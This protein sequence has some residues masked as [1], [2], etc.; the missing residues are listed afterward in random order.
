[1]NHRQTPHSMLPDVDH[2]ENARQDFVMNF[3]QHL[4]H[5]VNPGTTLAYEQRVEPA[6][7]KEHS[8]KPEG[9]DEV[10]K[11]MT[12]DPY[13]QIWSAMQRNSQM[14]MWDS[15]IDSVERTLP[16]MID[17]A[18]GSNGPSSARLADESFEVPRY[19][20]S[21][22]IHLQPGGYHTDSA[23]EDIAAGMIY[24]TAVPIYALGMMG[25]ENDAT[26]E[27]IVNFYKTNYAHHTPKRVLDLGCAIGNSTVP[28]AKAYPDAEVHGI[29]VGAPCLRYGAARA[30]AM[31][32]TLHLSQQNAEQTDFPDNHFDVIGSALLFHETSRSAVTNIMTEAYRILKPGGVMVH[33][34]AFGHVET[35]T[36]IQ[37]FLATW[38]VFN[39]NE[40][41]LK[42]LRCI[43]I[44][45]EVESCGFDRDKIAFKQTP[46]MTGTR[47]TNEGAAGYM[48]GFWDV[49][50][51]V[52]EK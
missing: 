34:D 14:M 12:K 42:Q 22:D 51:L 45:D 20:T 8:R 52:A 26:G 39:N 35:T 29:D 21:Y 38:E 50:V 9:H 36:P 13:Y 6:F 37:E 31:G 40:Y 48:M 17:Q 30:N 3:R 33:M 10:R 1:M 47:A 2:D 18:R 46:Y 41:F 19:H 24:D 15:V 25:Q 7:E 32:H 27:T 11:V 43:N 28:W 16:D 4:A 5:N 49:N 44:I 23:T